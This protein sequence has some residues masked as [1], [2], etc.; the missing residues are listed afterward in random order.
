MD[1]YFKQGNFNVPKSDDDIN[2]LESLAN[3]SS[4][5]DKDFDDVLFATSQL[6]DWKNFDRDKAWANLNSNIFRKNRISLLKYASAAVLLIG[7]TIAFYVFSIGEATSFVAEG[8]NKY[9]V[10]PDGSDVVLAPYSELVISAGFNDSNRDISL[11]G[12]GYFNVV[13]NRSLPF[14]VDMEKGDVEVLGTTF[15]IKQDEEQLDVKLVSGVLKVTDQNAKSKIINSN[16]EASIGDD[17]EIESNKSFDEIDLQFED[18]VLKNISL[19]EAVQRINGVYNRE[20]IKIAEDSDGLKKEMIYMT[21]KNS[22]AIDFLRGLK[23]IFSIKVTNY[24]GSY[25]IL[26]ENL[27]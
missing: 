21:V 16:Q 10:L 18:L 5:E 27:K 25:V 3:D 26:D 4:I 1:H 6:R 17:I 8:Q 22:S 11:K 19:G 12:N 20:I 2:T 14:R 15:Y 23:M 24:N 7:I 9:V 13:K